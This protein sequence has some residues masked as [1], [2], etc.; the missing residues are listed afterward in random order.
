MPAASARISSVRNAGCATRSRNSTRTSGRSSPG[1]S[2]TSTGPWRS[3]LVN[4]PETI[5]GRPLRPLLPLLRSLRRLFLDEFA[6][7]VPEGAGH[8]TEPRA[9]VP[10]ASTSG[11]SSATATTRSPRSAA[12][13]SPASTPRTHVRSSSSGDASPPISR[14]DAIH[15]LRPAARERRLPL[16]LGRRARCGV[17]PRDGRAVR[18]RLAEPRASTGSGPP[19][20]GRGATAS[21]GVRSPWSGPRPSTSCAA[22]SPRRP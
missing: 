12:R 22:C 15:P 20:A 13:T 4:L 14:V 19:R 9:S 17:R 16:L 18:D 5:K 21:E 7:D 3:G 8:S 10:P 1:T 6:A 11:C 2:P